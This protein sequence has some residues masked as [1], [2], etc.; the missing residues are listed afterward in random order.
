MSA[1]APIA[2]I[3]SFRRLQLHQPLQRQLRNVGHV[4]VVE[5]LALL[6]PPHFRF[7]PIADIDSARNPG[8]NP[9]FE[10]R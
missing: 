6:Q 2:D 10:E 5:A 7:V 1:L 9:G 3:L 4:I 8:D